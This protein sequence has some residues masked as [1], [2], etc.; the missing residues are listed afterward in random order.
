MQSKDH[1]DTNYFKS[2]RPQGMGVTKPTVNFLLD[3]KLETNSQQPPLS[4]GYKEKEQLPVL[5]QDHVAQDKLRLCKHPNITLN[6]S[7]HLHLPSAGITGMNHHTSQL[8]HTL[9]PNCHPGAQEEM[10]IEKQ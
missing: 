9:A 3:L 4:R 7:S 8:R 5:R 1:K 2:I 6:F 10:V